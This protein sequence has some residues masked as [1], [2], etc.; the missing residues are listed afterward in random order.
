MSDNEETPAED[1]EG[2]GEVDTVDKQ[3]DLNKDNIEATSPNISE[4]DHYKDN[5]GDDAISKINDGYTYW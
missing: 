3:H 5:D 2:V 4:E 1:N